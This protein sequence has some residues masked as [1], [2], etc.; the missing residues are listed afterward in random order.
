MNTLNRLQDIPLLP[1]LLNPAT[2][3]AAA[4]AAGSAQV[5][6]PPL[7]EEVADGQFKLHLTTKFDQPQVDAILKC[8]AHVQP[9]GSSDGSNGGWAPPVCLIQGPPGT[10][11]TYTVLGVL[12]LWHMVLYHR[13][14]SSLDTV[15]QQ[16][17]QNSGPGTRIGG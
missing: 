16:L 1:Y 5:G 14:Y 9:S 11:K 8:A 3:H 10:G 17:V 7:P 4:A 13:H 15:V 6:E 12:N 2:T